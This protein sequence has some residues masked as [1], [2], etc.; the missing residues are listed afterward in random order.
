MLRKFA[1]IVIFVDHL[2]IIVFVV[3]SVAGTLFAWDTF[4]IKISDWNIS[5]ASSRLQRIMT[6]YTQS[7]T[8]R[9]L[10]PWLLPLLGM[11]TLRLPRPLFGVSRLGTNSSIRSG[12]KFRF[13][14][15]NPAWDRVAPEGIEYK[16]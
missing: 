14:A 4:G 5:I 16:S 12:Q 3:V 8:P 13:V 6:T 2:A 10:K 11:K 15:E 1:I 7:N 9:A